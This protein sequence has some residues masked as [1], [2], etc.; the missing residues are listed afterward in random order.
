MVDFLNGPLMALAARHAEEVSNIVLV[1]AVTRSLPMVVGT[2]LGL[3]RNL[4]HATPT[5]VQ[6]IKLYLLLF[7]LNSYFY[8]ISRQLYAHTNRFCCFTGKYKAR[9]LKSTDRACALR[10][11]ALYFPVQQQNRLV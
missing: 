10:P 3:R 11:R 2:V 5:S 1:H 9:G 6:V 4:Q 7:L 8:T